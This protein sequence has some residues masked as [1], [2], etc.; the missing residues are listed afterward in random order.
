MKKTAYLLI[1]LVVILTSCVDSFLDTTSPS[2]QSTENVFK[3]T[4]FT[5]AAMQGLYALLT[6]S[7]VY[8][9]KIST[10]KSTSDL[11]LINSYSKI[12]IIEVLSG[13]T[14]FAVKVVF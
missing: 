13:K 3:S 12:A 8:G 4:F 11:E 9:Q 7:T 14:R 10:Y 6:E 2:Q 1:A 5:E